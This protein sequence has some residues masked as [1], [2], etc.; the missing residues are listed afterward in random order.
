[1]F[2]EKGDQ[3]EIYTMNVDGSDPKQITHVGAMSWAPY[4]YPTGDYLIFTNNTQGFAN[5][6]LFIVDA[7]GKHAP[8]RVTFTDGFDGLPVF[9]PDGKKLAWTSG[10]GA[11]GASQIYIAG[12]NDAA[13][14]QALGL[15]GAAGAAET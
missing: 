4:F 8:V 15:T 7:Q 11:G 1:R 2:N 6:E 5:F 13:A 10:R 14:R 9:S 12:W 3:A